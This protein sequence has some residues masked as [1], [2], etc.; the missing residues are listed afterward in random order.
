[1]SAILLCLFLLGTPK[2]MPQNILILKSGKM[3]NTVQAYTVDKSFVTF[4]DKKGNVMQLPKK[5]VDFHKTRQY[6]E[7]KRQ[8]LQE[9]RQKEKDNLQHLANLKPNRDLT[10]LLNQIENRLTTNHASLGA[11][12]PLKAMKPKSFDHKPEVHPP[13]PEKVTYSPELDLQKLDKELQFTTTEL[14]MKPELRSQTYTSKNIPN[15]PPIQPISIENQKTVAL[16]DFMTLPERPIIISYNGLNDEDD[17]REQEAFTKRSLEGT[18]RNENLTLL[19]NHTVIAFEWN[20]GKKSMLIGNWKLENEAQDIVLVAMRG[21]VGPMLKDTKLEEPF[22]KI[23][24]IEEGEL[25]VQL[26]EKVF[27][28]KK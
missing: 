16:K 21:K 14:P 2:E 6:Y 18:W 9:Q 13:T 12:S 7:K 10:P 28:L 27:T 3:I 24:S 15:L 19:F 8:S 22:L 1:M 20:E 25:V 17:L 23:V 26:K 5:V 4:K 11:A